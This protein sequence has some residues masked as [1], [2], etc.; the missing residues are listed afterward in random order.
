MHARAQSDVTANAISGA[1]N[2]VQA[3]PR[4]MD[5]ALT[6]CPP[7]GFCALTV[8]LAARGRDFTR[9]HVRARVCVYAVLD[10]YVLTSYMIVRHNGVVRDQLS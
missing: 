3:Y 6:L 7:S 5:S 8:S 9:G 4:A 10:Y 1:F 2:H